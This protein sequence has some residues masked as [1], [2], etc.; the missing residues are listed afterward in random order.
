MRLPIARRSWPYITM[1]FLPCIIGFLIHWSAGIILLLPAL[2]VLN[3]F[4]DPD[5]TPPELPESIVLSPADGKVIS[6]EKGPHPDFPDHQRI[7]IFMNIFDVHVNRAPCKGILKS[8]LHFPGR[9]LPA[10]H[11]T[12]PVENE[13]M[14]LVVKGDQGEFLVVLVAGL[15]ARRI[16]AWAAAGDRL[17]RN[18]RI[19]MIKLGSRVDIHVPAGGKILVSPGT[20]VKAGLTPVYDSDIEQ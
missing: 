18:Q 14:E 4:R 3:F 17:L 12:A 9:F 2:L 11:P 5:R 1:A 10:D 8:V 7:S 20:R 13:R 15:I 16:Y 6:I 19:S